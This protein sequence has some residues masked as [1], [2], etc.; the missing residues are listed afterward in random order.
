MILH[1]HDVSAGLG[2]RFAPPADVCARL[3][4]QTRGWPHWSSPGWHDA[5]ATED[6]WSDLLT[7]SGRRP[8]G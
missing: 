5:G 6:P 4:D 8:T 1:G 3:R 2:V 7:A